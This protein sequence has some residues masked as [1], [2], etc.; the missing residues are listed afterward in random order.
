MFLMFLMSAIQDAVA[1]V[2]IPSNL[3]EIAEVY[4]R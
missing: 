1:G 2:A 3:M 4:L